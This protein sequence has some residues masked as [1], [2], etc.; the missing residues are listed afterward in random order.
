MADAGRG[1]TVF[2]TLAE[3]PL[4]LRHYYRGGLVRHI[5]RSHYI[6][7]GMRRTRALREFDLLLY[8]RDLSLPAPQPY[9]CRV[10]R[11]ALLY[12][13][14]L[15]TYRLT[16][17][18]LAQRLLAD[19]CLASDSESN[20]RLWHRIGH[21]IARFHSAGVFHADLNAH[22][23]MIDDDEQMALLD[24]DRGSL[25]ALTKNPAGQGWCLQNMSRLQRSLSKLARL[26]SAASVLSGSAD[27]GDS[28]DSKAADFNAADAALMQL[29]F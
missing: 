27:A 6:F 5:S 18:T 24:F 7:C 23:I 9:A 17:R 3:Q 19:G 8:L 15:V 11:K 22:N 21:M 25:K 29:S 1:N 10:K 16:G 2:F 28:D 13:A 20:A 4:V 26:S 12:Q 14:S